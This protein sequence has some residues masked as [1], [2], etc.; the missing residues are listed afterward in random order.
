M[1]V[2]YWQNY[3]GIKHNNIPIHTK[4]ERAKKGLKRL[5]SGRIAKKAT[6]GALKKAAKRTSEGLDDFRLKRAPK[7]IVR[8]AALKRK[9]RRK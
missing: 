1:S 7:R 5:K 3:D 2:E 6:R 4:A 9:T 8:K